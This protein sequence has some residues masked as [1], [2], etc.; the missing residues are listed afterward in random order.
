MK[1]ENTSQTLC[2]HNRRNL[3]IF[4]FHDVIHCFV[5]ETIFKRATMVMETQLAGKYAESR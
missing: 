1:P 3:L 2:E 4:A 5:H